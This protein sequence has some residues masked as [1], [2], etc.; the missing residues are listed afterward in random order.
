MVVTLI[1]I[2]GVHQQ[3]PFVWAFLLEGE[4]EDG[5]WGAP[6]LEAGV[7]IGEEDFGEAQGGDLSV[8]NV[9]L[10][11]EGVVVWEV[12]GLWDG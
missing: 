8:H 6:G 1:D 3:A 4:G 10:G 9:G 7:I 12:E 2:S 11:I 5:V